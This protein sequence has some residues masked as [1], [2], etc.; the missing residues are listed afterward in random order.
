MCLIASVLALFPLFLLDFLPLP[1]FLLLSFLHF[2]HTCDLTVCFGLASL[3]ICL[4]ILQQVSGVNNQHN[5]R[6][7]VPGVPDVSGLLK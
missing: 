7:V 3:E 5:E 2:C 6:K 1:F 4:F